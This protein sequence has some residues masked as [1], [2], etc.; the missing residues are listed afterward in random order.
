[1]R[2]AISSGVSRVYPRVCGGTVHFE[3]ALK[4]YQGL[5]PRVRGNRDT[6]HFLPSPLRSIPA[7]AGE[8]QLP[9][10]L[11]RA[12]EVYPRVCGGTAPGRGEEHPCRGLS[13]RV[14]G[15]LVAVVSVIALLRSI[16]ACAGEPQRPLPSSAQY[17]VY[18]RVCGGTLST[19]RCCRAPNGLS[20][21][22]R[23]NQ[24]AA[25]SP[26][27][28]S[29]SIPACA[30]EPYGRTAFSPL[31]TVYPRVCGGTAQRAKERLL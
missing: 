19:T 30:G 3:Y 6:P 5:S 21:R 8:P 26:V 14:R 29:G 11:Q 23:G 20:P 25:S 18:P 28:P 15:N 4:V 10:A 1:M 27:L 13:P 22:V 12:I 9:A 17:S 2:A 16:P 24:S 31:K 7:C